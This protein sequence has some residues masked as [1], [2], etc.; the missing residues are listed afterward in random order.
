MAKR[1]RGLPAA[2]KRYQMKPSSKKNAA[3]VGG[4]MGRGHVGGK[5]KMEA[6]VPW[7]PDANRWVPPWLHGAKVE[8]KSKRRRSR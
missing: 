5:R 6:Q 3:T 2:L 1:K 4:L 8:T 7:A